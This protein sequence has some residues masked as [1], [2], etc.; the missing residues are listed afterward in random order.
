[1]ARLACTSLLKIGGSGCPGIREVDFRIGTAPRRLRNS[2]WTRGKGQHVAI[3]I[4]YP[5]LAGGANESFSWPG[6]AG[7]VFITLTFG[8]FA[9]YAAKQA[10]HFLDIERRNR[11]LALELEAIGPFLAPLPP[12]L[13]NAFRVKIGERSFGQ[14]ET[15]TGSTDGRSPA[16]TLDLLLKALESKQAQELI[17]LLK[18]L[19][20]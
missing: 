15:A 6:F 8:A 19:K 10:D 16:T 11:R 20:P 7:R 1:M 5:S 3:K 17:D 13:Q 2:I 12:D 14:N 4:F 9:A 18:K